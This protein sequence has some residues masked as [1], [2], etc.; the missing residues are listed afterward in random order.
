MKKFK[1]YLG[2]FKNKIGPGIITGAA[3]DDPSGILTYLIAGAQTGLS[4]LW[5]ALLT[6][7]L[8]I[9]VQEM[10]A[11][12]GLA[13]KQGLVANMKKVFPRW[14]LYLIVIFQVSATTLNI[15]ADISA[16]TTSLA[17]FVPIPVFVS[18]T[19][20]VFLLLFVL[21]HF[22]YRK[23][24]RIFH[25]LTLPLFA[26]IASA[27]MTHL[28]LKELL[29][30]TF[31][32]HISFDKNTLIILAGVLGTTISPYLFFWHAS[33]EV[34]EQRDQSKDLSRIV[35]TKREMSD[36][37]TD[38]L[39]GMAFSNIVTYFIIA[40]AAA[41]FHQQGITQVVSLAE[42]TKI[43]IPLAGQFSALLFT[44][45]I[46]GTGILALPVLAGS[47]AYAVSEAFGF[48]EG[49]DKKYHQ[50]PKFYLV[51]IATTVLGLILSFLPINPVKLLFYTAVSY[52]ILAP[53]LIGLIIY[54]ANQKSIMGDKCNSKTSNLISVAAFVLMG[55]VALALFFMP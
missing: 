50:A 1:I 14:L 6:I 54:I 35:V 19:L 5:T 26:Y 9:G 52:G 29:L 41:T 23:L 7:P 40:G 13:T 15:A 45:G 34:E 4:L 20:L 24:A 12:I 30:N 36:M 55:F 42:A 10:C 46:V 47:S 2:S 32:P 39:L 21:I 44:I 31:I 49:L 48:Q 22:S 8:L 3:D 37:R 17:L 27:L 53:I 25:L 11:R 38:V 28:D 43:L 16:I 18:G 51:I 33:E